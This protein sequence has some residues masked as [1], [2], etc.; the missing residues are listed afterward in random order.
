MISKQV[1]LIFL[2]FSKLIIISFFKIPTFFSFEK[3]KNFIF[4][5]FDGRLGNQLFQAAT[6]LS[7][8]NDNNSKI[9]FYKD[10][11]RL[12]K[13]LYPE[14]RKR[15]LKKKIK[16]SYKQKP[17][18]N[19]IKIP[20]YPDMKLT[21]YFESEKYFK[22]N[23][24]L[25]LKSIQCPVKIRRYILKKYEKI[26]SHPKTVALHIRTFYDDFKNS[27]K[28]IY[29]DFPPPNEDFLK[30]AINLFDKDSQFIVCSD[31]IASAKE[32]LKKIDRNFI[33]IEKEKDY[34]DFFILS[35]CKNMITSNST[36]SWWAA[37]LIKNPDKK[38]IVKDPWFKNPQRK[39][40]DIIP[41]KWIK[42]KVE[43][44]KKLPSF[45]LN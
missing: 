20:Y 31:H 14:I 11:H 6:A 41:E 43:D 7:L 30:K 1:K 38:I 9:Y 37:Y 17:P 3:K 29:N 21:G 42:I 2:S 12:I 8:A 26:L 4:M 15:K 35:L 22:H 28:S 44:S 39:T 24:A 10:P 36:F 16:F 25:I 34:V 5:N 45:T 18:F 40:D 23:K 19:Y 33:F 32:I 27:G 13:L